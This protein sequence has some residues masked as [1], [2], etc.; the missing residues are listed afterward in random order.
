MIDFHTHPVMIR[1][2]YDANPDFDRIVNDVFGFHFP[3]QPLEIFLREMDAA[4]VDAA[5]LLPLDCTTAHSCKIPSNE[6]VADLVEKNQRF[7]GF[8]SVD[9]LLTEAPRQLERA[10]TS[11]GLRGLKLDPALQRFDLTNRER[12]DPLFSIC[13][14]HAIPVLIH[15]GLSWAPLGQAKYAHPLPLEEIA[16]AHPS[17]NFV[18]AHFAWPWVNEAVMLALK[19]RNVYLD[20]AIIFSGTPWEAFEQVFQKN[21]GL[22]TLERS[23]YQQIV[24][25]TNY[26]RTDMRRS[27]RG[28]QQVGLSQS[29][30]D[31][32][33]HK[34][35][36]HLLKLKQEAL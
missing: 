32:I 10:I 5:V 28:I 29:L 14:E 25:G 2:L 11:L 22:L 31:F 16:Q 35:P 4:G 20:T 27:V 30:L 8:A 19:Y 1:E 23:L 17:V 18:I 13:A 15:C 7:I 3:P 24:F 9:P 33:F 6:V 36:S 21:I 26:P 12:L 34:N